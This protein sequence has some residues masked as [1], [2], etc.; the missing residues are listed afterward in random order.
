[1]AHDDLLSEVRHVLGVGRA[2]LAPGF[3]EAIE[4]MVRDGA[5]GE[6]STGY[7]LRS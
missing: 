6:G 7:A 1:M 4:T 5:I 2:A 3:D